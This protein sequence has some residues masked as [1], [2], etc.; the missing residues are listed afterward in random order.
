MS[1]YH[2]PELFPLATMIIDLASSSDDLNR[3]IYPLL[4]SLKDELVR[5]HPTPIPQ[6]D[7][8]D[9]T[10][11]S[12]VMNPQARNFLVHVKQNAAADLA[13]IAEKLA[14]ESGVAFDPADHHSLLHWFDAN[15]EALAPHVRDV[16]V[17]TRV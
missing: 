2:D 16:G 1:K 4:A 11:I 15:W 8:P 14:R 13:Q 17:L 7:T 3:Q 9:V 10:G 12:S 6:A 5:L